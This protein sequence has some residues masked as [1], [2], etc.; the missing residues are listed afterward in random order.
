MF[1]GQL[2]RYIVRSSVDDSFYEEQGTFI[3]KTEDEKHYVFAIEKKNEL[4]FAVRCVDVDD[5][6]SF[7]YYNNINTKHNN[8]LAQVIELLSRH[9]EKTIYCF[10]SSD[11]TIT[12]SIMDVYNYKDSPR[13][14]TFKEITSLNIKAY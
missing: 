13:N 8:S 1:K 14:D 4:A 11:R 3:R 7:V 6:V 2:C 5:L 12:V 10:P 9:I